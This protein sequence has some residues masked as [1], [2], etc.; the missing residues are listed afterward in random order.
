[1]MTLWKYIFDVLSDS[2]RDTEIKP[3]KD[4]GAGI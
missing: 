2:S 3:D 1:M 4:Y